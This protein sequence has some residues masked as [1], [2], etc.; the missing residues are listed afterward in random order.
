MEQPP[1]YGHGVQT[2]IQ[3]LVGIPLRTPPR[4]S[5]GVVLLS[6][7]VW[8]GRHGGGEF[9]NWNRMLYKSSPF[10]RRPDTQTHTALAAAQ[11]LFL[12]IHGQ[13]SSDNDL[14]CLSDVD[15][16]IL[17]K[18]PYYRVNNFLNLWGL[19]AVQIPISTIMALPSYAQPPVRPVTTRKSTRKLV[20]STAFVPKPPGSP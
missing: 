4:G 11:A 13:P 17:L 5:R 9:S 16:P 8:N 19:V 10:N 2:K 1:S 6:P 15:L 14:V 7:K 12:P 3:G 20:A 18:V